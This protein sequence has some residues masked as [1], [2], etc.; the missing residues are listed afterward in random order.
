[1]SEQT[2]GVVLTLDMCVTRNEKLL[3]RLLTN[4]NDIIATMYTR[5]EMI[6][7]GDK[8]IE[9]T[10]YELANAYAGA[11]SCEVDLETLLPPKK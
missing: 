8:V 9:K 1:M 5:E 6:S 7:F 10:S 4:N 11:W 2:Q 3:F